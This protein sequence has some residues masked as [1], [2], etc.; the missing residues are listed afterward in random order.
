MQLDLYLQLQQYFMHMA[1]ASARIM[2]CFMLL[3]FF[4]NNVLSGTLRLPVAMLVGLALWPAEHPVIEDGG[5]SFLVMVITKEAIIG[6]IIACF[7]SLPFW[8]LHAVGSMIDNQRGATLSSSIDPI[9]GVDTSE[10]ANFLNLFSAV[11]VLQNGGLVVMIEVFQHSYQLWQPLTLDVPSIHNILTFLG[12]VVSRALVI[13][14]PVIIVFLLSELLLGMLAR[15][16]PQLNSFSLA[17]TVK[18]LIGFLLLL[19]YFSPIFPYK[20]IEMMFY[21]VFHEV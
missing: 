2:P 18:S 9:S 7:I 8:V 21:P 13:A 1:L 14:S 20:I 16:S 3:P 6:L 17:L 19:L 4:T 15:F 12:I 5:Y 10:L 11:L